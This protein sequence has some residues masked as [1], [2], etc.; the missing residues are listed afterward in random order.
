MV[1]FQEMPLDS[2]H[3]QE[4]FCLL[5]EEPLDW[6][7][8]SPLSLRGI[9]SPFLVLTLVSWLST[10]LGELIKKEQAGPRFFSGLATAQELRM[11]VQLVQGLPDKCTELVIQPQMILVFFFLNSFEENSFWTF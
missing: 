3:R 8:Q 1:E 11:R 5:R 9:Q 6:D 10:Y 7:S 4:A 2:E